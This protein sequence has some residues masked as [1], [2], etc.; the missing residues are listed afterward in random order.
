[1][2]KR[3]ELSLDDPLARFFPGFARAAH[4]V[5]VRHLLGHSSGLLDGEELIPGGK[6]RGWTTG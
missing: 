5:K 6:T 3:G 1:V 2:S 4:G